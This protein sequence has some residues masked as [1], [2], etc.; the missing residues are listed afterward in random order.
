MQGGTH[1][2]QQETGPTLLELLLRLEGDVRRHLEPIR[3][4]PLR[5]DVLLFLCRHVEATVTDAAFALGVRLPKLSVVVK[6]LVRLG[7]VTKR[8]SVN[9]ARVVCLSLGRRGTALALKSEQRVRQVEATLAEQDPKSPRHEPAGQ[10]RI[11]PCQ[12]CWLAPTIRLPARRLR[13][14]QFVHSVAS[15]CNAL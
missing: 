15:P 3:M 9:D 5:A 14:S 8:R 1:K 10:P 6:A 12:V 4:T 7:W 11:D 13:P 2:D